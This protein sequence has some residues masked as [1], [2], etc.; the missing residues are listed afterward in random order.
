M[1]GDS[2][3][4]QHQ[5]VQILLLRFK[6]RLWRFGFFQKEDQFIGE[7]GKQLVDG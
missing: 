1:N 5:S 2:H 4:L 7:E 3:D 6:R